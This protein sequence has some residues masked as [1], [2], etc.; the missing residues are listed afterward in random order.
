[1][2]DG[3]GTALQYPRSKHLFIHDSGRGLV[4]HMSICIASDITVDN[5]LHTGRL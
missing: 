2:I 1:M 5:R 3:L 4:E